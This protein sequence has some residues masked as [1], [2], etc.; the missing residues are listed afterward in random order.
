MKVTASPALAAIIIFAALSAMP[1][2]AKPASDPRIT[3]TP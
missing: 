2:Q 1:S 3:G